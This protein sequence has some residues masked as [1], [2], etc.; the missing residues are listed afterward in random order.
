MNR[1][2]LSVAL[3]VLLS[4]P[5]AHAQS[6]DSQNAQDIQAQQGEQQQTPP[7]ETDVASDVASAEPATEPN[8]TAAPNDMEQY[9]N[10]MRILERINV[11]T[12]LAQSTLDNQVDPLHKIMTLV[13]NP[14]STDDDFAEAAKIAASEAVRLDTLITEGETLNAVIAATQTDGSVP[15]DMV[16]PLVTIGTE[17]V[18]AAIKALR[19]QRGGFLRLAGTPNE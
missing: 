4:A 9:E 7:P 5:V 12:K 6:Q 15:Q 14:E 11:Y 16:K 19:E 13:A 1:I 3:L 10:A 2:H 17:K 8:D 18:D